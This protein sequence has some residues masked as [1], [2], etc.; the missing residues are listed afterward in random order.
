MKKTKKLF[1]FFFAVVLTSCGCS[2]V[3]TNQTTSTKKYE[4]KIYEAGGCDQGIVEGHKAEIGLIP[5][6][7]IDNKAE[8]TAS[9]ERFGKKLNGTYMETEISLYYDNFQVNYFDAAEPGNGV[10][11]FGIRSDTGECV[12]YVNAPLNYSPADATIKTE[13]ECRRIARSTLSG[14]SD[15]SLYELEDQKYGKSDMYGGIYTFTFSKKVE[16]MWTNDRAIISVTCYGDIFSYNAK[17]LGSIQCT[18]L[19]DSYNEEKLKADLQTKLDG[20][21]KKALEESR[22]SDVSYELIE[23][24]LSNING[25]LAI[26]Y[27]YGVTLTTSQ[28]ITFSDELVVLV[29]F[30]E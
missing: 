29:A 11:K 21:Y 6:T 1:A 22:Y 12:H 20:I 16:G 10:C 25:Q 2:K 8:K 4:C 17:K 23:R 15:E 7:I 9:M 19:P 27:S 30:L 3:N 24:R 28:N 14:L 13:D 5:Q 18:K 26:E